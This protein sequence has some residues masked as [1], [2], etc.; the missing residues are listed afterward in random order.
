MCELLLGRCTLLDGAALLE[1]D[2]G[3]RDDWAIEELATALE[4]LIGLELLFGALLDTS[5]PLLD[6]AVE[7]LC[8]ELTGAELEWVDELTGAEEE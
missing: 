7:E 1:D 3:L 4:E 6:I 8:V 5:C 2:C